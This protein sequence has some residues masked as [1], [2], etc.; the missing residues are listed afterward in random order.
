MG[1]FAVIV[2]FGRICDSITAAGGVR[3]S[4]PVVRTRADVTERMRSDSTVL[5]AT[6]GTMTGSDVVP[7]GTTM[8]PPGTV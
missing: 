3:R 6:V 7:G 4:D 2:S 5:S 8:L 1:L